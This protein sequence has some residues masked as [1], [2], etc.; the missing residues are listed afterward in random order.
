M[1]ILQRPKKSVSTKVDL[2]PMV[3]LGFLLITF[4]MMVSSFSKPKALEVL[5][6]EDGEETPLS[7]SKTAILILGTRGK[8]YTYSLPDSIDGSMDFPIDSMDYSQSGVRKYIQRRQSEVEMKWGD[9]Q[10]LFVIIKPLQGSSYKNV[11][12][13]LDEMM[14][15]GVKR[16]AILEPNSQVD[17]IVVARVGEKWK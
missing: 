17:S 5:K 13:V 10:K 12:D 11:V 1:E 4:F 14:I 6:P 15:N 16:Y 2:T 7:Q 3:D 8:I 9:K